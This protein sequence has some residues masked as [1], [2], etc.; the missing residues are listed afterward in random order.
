[1]TGV[2]FFGNQP[3]LHFADA[4]AGL[5]KEFALRNV[6]SNLSHVLPRSQ[7]GYRVLRYQYVRMPIVALDG[8]LDV[9]DHENSVGA[10]GQGAAGAHIPAHGFV[11][12][13]GRNAILILIPRRTSMR[14]LSGPRG[15]EDAQRQQPLVVRPAHPHRHRYRVS[16]LDASTVR[17]HRGRRVHRLRQD[18]SEHG[19]EI[20]ARYSLLP[21]SASLLRLSHGDAQGVLDGHHLTRRRHRPHACT[22]HR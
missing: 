20:R 15:A 9:L 16:V 5:E 2:V 4:R 1:M 14:L 6:A 19:R 22:I 8:P 18:T 11:G 21:R 17:R 3:Y 13:G 12:C 10:I 7:R